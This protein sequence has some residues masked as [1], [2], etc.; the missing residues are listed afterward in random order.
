MELKFKF[1]KFYIYFKQHKVSNDFWS[2]L[3]KHESS[4]LANFQTLKQ[5]FYIILHHN[6]HIGYLHDIHLHHPKQKLN[7]FEV[8]L[9]V[10][11]MKS[12]TK[13][14][15]HCHSLTTDR[16]LAAAS[17]WWPSDPCLL[18]TRIVTQSISSLVMWWGESRS[19]GVECLWWW[20]LKCA[21]IF[22]DEE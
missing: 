17:V 12:L 11:T 3:K 19:L 9:L 6:L 22:S 20:A 16:M 1:R 14:K 15:L 8:L 4:F 5:T 13:Q 7:P 21:Q 10:H 18:N 2:K